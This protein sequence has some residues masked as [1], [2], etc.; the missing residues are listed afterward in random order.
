[1][2][3]FQIVAKLPYRDEKLFSLD[4]NGRA[5]DHG[6]KLQQSRIRSNS[7]KPV[8]TTGQWNK[9]PRVD[10]KSLS[11]GFSTKGWTGLHLAWFRN[12]KSLQEVG[13]EGPCHPFQPCDSIDEVLFGTR[14]N[15]FPFPHRAQYSQYKAR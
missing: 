6:L 10:M 11:L 1:M 9:L 7:R 12:S 5:Y 8:K 2:M 15:L 4:T 3:V 14:D 13:L